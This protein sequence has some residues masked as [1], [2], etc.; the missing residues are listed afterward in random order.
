M[1]FHDSSSPGRS[2]HYGPQPSK[3]EVC[4]PRFYDLGR[5]RCVKRPGLSQDLAAAGGARGCLSPERTP[6]AVASSLAGSSAVT[7]LSL[8]DE[9]A[10][11][12]GIL[13]PCHACVSDGTG[14]LSGDEA[15]PNVAARLIP[16]GSARTGRPGA[17]TP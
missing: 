3:L 1:R 12:R 8:R 4:P 2:A 17:G 10:S 16:R 7:S 15:G 13:A 5:V 9:E 11:P 6:Q 14:A